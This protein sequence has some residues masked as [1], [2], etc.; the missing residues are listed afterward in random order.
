[1]TTN[2]EKSVVYG[3]AGDPEDMGSVFT[4]DD[5]KGLLWKGVICY[6]APDYIGV[7]C[8]TNLSCCTIS[9][10]GKYLAIASNERLGTVLIYEL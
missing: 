4:Y 6:E 10:D 5:E 3:V 9:K 2:P 1:M 8:C 7:V